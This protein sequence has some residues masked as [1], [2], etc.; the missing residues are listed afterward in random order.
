MTNIKVI[1]ER[2]EKIYDVAFTWIPYTE[3]SINGDTRSAI[4][5]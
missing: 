1:S 2:K 5:L 3:K 4:M